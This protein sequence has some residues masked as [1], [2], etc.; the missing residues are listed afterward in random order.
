MVCRNFR[1]TEMIVLQTG[2]LQPTPGKL[3]EF[4]WW[5]GKVIN[6]FFNSFNQ[7]DLPPYETYDKLRHMLLTACTECPEGFGFA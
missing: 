6:F 3:F 1:S 5:I 4:E 2:Y 7:L